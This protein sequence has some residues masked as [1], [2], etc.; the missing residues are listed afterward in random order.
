[1]EKKIKKYNTMLKPD[2][3]WRASFFTLMSL[4]K[5]GCVNVIYRINSIGVKC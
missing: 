5:C 1:M 3:F 4:A 2:F